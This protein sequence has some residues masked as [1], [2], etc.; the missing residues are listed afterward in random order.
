MNAWAWLAPTLTWVAGLAMAAWAWRGMAPAMK[1]LGK[2]TIVELQRAGNAEQVERI[3]AAWT[4]KAGTP[5]E[6]RTAAARQSLAWDLPLITGYVLF[7]AGLAWWSLEPAYRTLGGWGAVWA[8]LATLAALAAGGCDLAE[9]KLCGSLLDEPATDARAKA[10]KRL[11]MAK[12][13]LLAFAVAMLVFVL[14]PM[15][16]VAG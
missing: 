16:V 3:K 7:L 11:A 10:V 14:L 5:G 6:N 8:G 13:A 4:G 12:F 1:R 15:A 9:D 2:P